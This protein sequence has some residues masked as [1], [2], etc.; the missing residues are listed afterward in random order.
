MENMYKFLKSWN[1]CNK[2]Q[3]QLLDNATKTGLDAVTPAFKTAIHKTSEATTEFIENKIA[4][5]IVKPRSMPEGN[6]TEIEEIIIPQE[7]REKIG[8]IG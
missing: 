7:K 4:D 8:I 2:Y 6:S 3:K 5:K 1:L